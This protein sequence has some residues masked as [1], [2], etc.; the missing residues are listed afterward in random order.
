MASV[1]ATG[2]PKYQTPA[3]NIPLKSHEYPQVVSLKQRDLACQR[4]VFFQ[5]AIKATNPT[6]PTG[7]SPPG[8]YSAQT[9]ELT[10]QNV[11]LVLEDVRPYLI[12]DGGNVDVVSVEDGVVSLK[13]QGG[14]DLF[15]STGKILEGCVFYFCLFGI[16]WIP[17]QPILRVGLFLELDLIWYLHI[18]RGK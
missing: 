3:R 1:T 4:K 18:Y 7:S 16:I 15:F 12:S 6:A 11:D 10:A 14:S 2:L 8:L 9:F 17:I 5:T 13:L